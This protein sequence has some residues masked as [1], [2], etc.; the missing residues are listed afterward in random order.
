MS[1]IDNCRKLDLRQSKF[2]SQ[3]NEL[4]LMD[5]NTT[6]SSFLRGIVPGTKWC[7]LGD[8]ANDY[9]DV[10]PRA[11]VDSCCRAHDHCPIRLKPF[12][13]GYGLVNLSLYTKSH[14]LC[15]DDFLKCLKS[16]QHPLADMLGNLYFNVMKFGC[17]KES[18]PDALSSS[19]SKTSNS[20]RCK[21]NVKRRR[22]SIPITLPQPMKRSPFVF[23]P[24]VTTPDPCI[25]ENSLQQPSVTFGRASG[26]LPSVESSE[27]PM[28]FVYDRDVR[29]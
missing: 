4:E 25:K 15:D 20:R 10:G 23:G 7:G 9:T 13:S 14:C 1:I 3:M 12:R 27:S 28:E 29:Y 5:N 24:S 2:I 26:S 21:P 6:L 17:L 8:S 18:N 16:S 22:M 11:L 19:P